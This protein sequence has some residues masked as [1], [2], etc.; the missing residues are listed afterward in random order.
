MIAGFT[1]IHCHILPGLDDGASDVTEAIR[2]MRIA[3]DDGIVSIVATPH[4]M[5]GEYENT[6]A[7]IE[8]AITLL[9]E[10][11]L[12]SGDV[13]A[14]DMPRLYIGGDVRISPDIIKMIEVGDIPTINNKGYLLIELPTFNIP[15]HTGE[16][17]FNLRQK[18]IIPIISHPE[19][20]LYILHRM[21]HLHSLVEYGA[22]C[23]VTAM[24]ITGDFGRDIQRAS[25]RMLKEGL[26]HFIASDA[27]D[28]RKRPPVLS[29]AYME[30]SRLFDEDTAK[31]MLIENP[32]R[33]IDGEWLCAAYKK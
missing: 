27:H 30:V 11:V 33:V 32:K 3:M 13:N 23:Q 1:D 19:R 25:I 2:M 22:L 7:G 14:G 8:E 6:K 20:N 29:R 15:P 12:R 31:R 10:S 16:L 5:D 26:V 28:S 24:S 17:I 21:E 4:I 18:H 9:Q